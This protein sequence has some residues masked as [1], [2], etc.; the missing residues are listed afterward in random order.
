MAWV[1]FTYQDATNR[2]K[3]FGFTWQ[4]YSSGPARKA[5][6]PFVWAQ[7]TGSAY[8]TSIYDPTNGTMS[9]GMIWRTSKGEGLAGAT[10]LQ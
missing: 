6:D 8:P 5:G 1:E 9:K 7:V 2:A 10:L 4:T 3:R